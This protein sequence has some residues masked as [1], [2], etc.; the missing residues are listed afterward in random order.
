METDV[1]TLFAT[2]ARG[3]WLVGSAVAFTALTLSLSCAAFGQAGD[4]K[5][6]LGLPEVIR[7]AVNASPE[8]AER[9]SEELSA[10]SDL[11]QAEAGY[12][13]QVDA[14]ALL[15][16]VNDARRPEVVGNRIIDPTTDFWTIG[17]FGRLNL[18]MT[19]PLYT[20]GKISNR[21]D[22]A[23]HGVVAREAGQVQTSNEIALQVK[24]LYYALVL[25]KAA[26]EA[27]KEA[28]G[29]FDEARSH[30]ER[31]LQAGSSNVVESELYRVDAYR[32]DAVRGRAEAEKGANISYFALKRLIGLPPDRDFEPADKTLAFKPGELDQP[33]AYIHKALAERPEFKQLEQGL[34]AQKSLVEASRADRYPSFFAALAGSFAA[35]P[36]REAFHNPYITDDFNHVYGGVVTGVNWHFDFGILKARVEKESA[37]Y[38][39]LSHT[40]AKAELNIPIQV[41]KSYEDVKEYKTAAEAYETGAVASRKWIV[42][43]LTG[44]DMGAG[45]A[46]DLLR[47]IERYGQNRGKYL[48]ALFNYNL[49][50]AQLE[51]AMGIRSW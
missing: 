29:F 30:M 48:E 44:F 50:L 10:K 23:Q 27:A 13:P 19:Q 43:A 18:A 47:A 28:G 49:S 12:Y 51:Y 6:V 9:R 22:A 42:A 11:A 35:A 45:T 7:M 21:R 36:G 25:S 26:I 38:E 33:E 4:E 40:K 31:L 5:M 15:G 8:M 34:A 14:T 24:E 46:D 17:V 20:F 39:R 41:M 2:Q 37:E 32:A 16:P 3:L 1:R